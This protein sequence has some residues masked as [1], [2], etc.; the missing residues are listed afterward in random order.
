MG[1][2]HMACQH[3]RRVWN[4]REVGKIYAMVMV[5]EN[6]EPATPSNIPVE[7]DNSEDALLYSWKQGHTLSNALQLFAMAGYTYSQQLAE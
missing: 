2:R 6:L 3:T 4:V 7:W 1:V 5:E